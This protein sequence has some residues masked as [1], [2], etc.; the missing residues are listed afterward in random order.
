MEI[1]YT[2][3]IDNANSLFR[4]AIT[5]KITRRLLCF[6]QSNDGSESRIQ[7]YHPFFLFRKRSTAD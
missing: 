4:R 5:M 3:L 2:S 6:L 7:I 1:L